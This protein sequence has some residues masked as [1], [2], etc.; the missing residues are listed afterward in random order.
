MP[1]RGEEDV[2]DPLVTSTLGEA[3]AVTRRV[4][5]SGGLTDRPS[6]KP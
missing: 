2:P 3:S 1:M 6:T 4:W 5:T